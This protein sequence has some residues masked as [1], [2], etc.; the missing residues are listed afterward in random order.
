MKLTIQYSGPF[1]SVTLPDSDG[2]RTIHQVCTLAKISL[3]SMDMR[4]AMYLKGLPALHA[5]VKALRLITP[6]DQVSVAAKK[7]T[8]MAAKW[9]PARGA[10]RSQPFPL[11]RV[12]CPERPGAVKGA[13]LLGAA[14]RTLDGED[15]SEMIAEEGK[16]G[17]KDWR[18][19]VRHFGTLARRL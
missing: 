1:N 5:D 14:K 16:A 13:P 2:A 3:A 15:R 19:V 4:R 12:C 17:A 8:K 18:K 11:L 10:V 6:G 7:G 9:S